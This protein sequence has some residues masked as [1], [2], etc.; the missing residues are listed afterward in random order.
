MR[1]LII[2]FFAISIV[3]IGCKQPDPVQGCTDRIATNFNSLAAVDDSSC[4]YID[5]TITFWQDGE[6]GYYEDETTGGLILSTCY[7]VA[8]TTRAF[9]DS[10]T[11]DMMIVS[12]SMGDFGFNL[13]IANRKNMEIFRHGYLVFDAMVPKRSPIQK[14]DVMV[15]GN[16]CFNIN[17]CSGV[18]QSGGVTVTTYQLDT[19][20]NKVV[21]PLMD[22]NGVNLVSTKNLMTLRQN[23]GKNDTVLV[24]NNIRWTTMPDEN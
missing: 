9:I 22:F 3:M 24:I 7:G 20:M 8:D 23:A 10:T 4:E 1:S 19:T 15:E 2:T 13:S 17:W 16:N 21:I 11:L 6:L 14:F 18:C 5:T 12:D